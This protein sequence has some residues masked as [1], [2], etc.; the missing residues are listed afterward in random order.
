M[1]IKS[2]KKEMFSGNVY[3]LT[4]SK[5]H[6]YFVSNCLVHNCHEESTTKG[7]H[8]DLDKLLEVIKDLPRGVEIAIGGGNPLSH[9]NL[10]PFLQKLKERGLIANITVNQFHIK[11]YF[12]DLEYIISNKLVYG[13]GISVSDG[14]LDNVELITN[15]TDNVVFHLIA[16]VNKI[17]IID[18]LL[19]FKNCKVLILGYKIFGFGVKYFSPEVAAEIKR[20][21]KL[22]PKYVT[23]CI[24]SFDNLAIEQLNVKDMLTKEA[25]EEF[26]MG[27]DFVFSMY[28]DA[29]NQEFAKTSRTAERTSFNDAGLIQFFQNKT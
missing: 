9:P 3:D 5:N 22:L 17:E 20:W 2:I 23:K 24:I 7:K 18:K 29:V 11:P 19:Q 26:Y 25:W 13:V 28:I 12:K 10:I 1:K 8:A 14:K 27:D 21:A 16:G 6:N 15:L 4:V